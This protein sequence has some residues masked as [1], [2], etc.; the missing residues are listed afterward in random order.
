MTENYIKYKIW[1]K[2]L[3]FFPKRIFYYVEHPVLFLVPFI[4]KLENPSIHDNR[5]NF[6]VAIWYS[7]FVFLILILT[8]I[9]LKTRVHY[10][11]FRSCQKTL[12]LQ[13]KLRLKAQ[14]STCQNTLLHKPWWFMKSSNFTI[15]IINLD[16][17]KK[18]W[19][20]PCVSY[21][22]VSILIGI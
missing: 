1:L 6:Q 5:S 12:S 22:L 21:S 18:Y 17:S 13:L 9:E 7:I 11:N 19:S 20:T 14:S 4:V 8:L 15:S 16:L 3:N 2:I 10:Q